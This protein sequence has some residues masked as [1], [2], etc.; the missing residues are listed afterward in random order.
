MNSTIEFI[1]HLINSA[2]GGIYSDTHDELIELLCIAKEE[3]IEK[4]DMLR[5]VNFEPKSEIGKW[6]FHH[7][8]DDLLKSSI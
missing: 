3:K 4:I 2:G 8:L 1:E 6:A 5:L 7:I